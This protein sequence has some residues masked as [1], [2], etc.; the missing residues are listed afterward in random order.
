MPS[1]KIGERPIVESDTRRM[2]SRTGT[3]QFPLTKREMDVLAF[4]ARGLSNK[5]IASLLR[6]SNQ[7]VK[8]HVTS[9]L[10]KLGVEG[11]TQARLYALRQ[12]RVRP[13]QNNVS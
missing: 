10:R 4:L 8:N 12:S 1:S 2:Q 13:N 6:I 3:V 5:E 11:R 7:T 9:I